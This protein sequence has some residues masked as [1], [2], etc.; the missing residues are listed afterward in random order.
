M[1]N[2]CLDA[3]YG[4][5]EDYTVSINASTGVAAVATPDFLVLPTTDGVQLLSDAATIGYTYTLFD[6]TGRSMATGRISADR[7]DLPM[8]SFARGAYTVQV[9]NGDARQVKRFV[10]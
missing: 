2:A 1:S 6:A 5:T 10:W 8:H 9:T 4:E 7:T 3:S